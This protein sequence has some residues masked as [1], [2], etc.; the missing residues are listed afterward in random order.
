MSIQ[1]TGVTTHGRGPS[2][3][4]GPP[5]PPTGPGRRFFGSTPPLLPPLTASPLTAKALYDPRIAYLT[6]VVSGWAYSDAATMA[7]QLPYYG[8]PNC[9]IQEFTV[10]ND[11]ML[12]VA[13]AYLVRSEDGSVGVLAF[14]GTMPNDF[15]NWL[16]DADTTLAHFQFGRVHAGFYGNLQ[17][18]WGAIAQAIDDAI[19]PRA[20]ATGQAARGP[21]KNL[22]VTG[23]SLGAAM[24]VVAAAR[25][26][27][28]DYAD[29][30]PYVRGVYT[31]G[32]P[33][34]GDQAFAEHY[35]TQL[36][37]YRHVYRFDVVPH[38]PPSDVGLFPHFGTELYSD[39]TS[40]WEAVVP[41]RT[42]QAGAV[43]A[44]FAVT[45]AS[46][47]ARRF[48]ILRS[49]KLRYSIEDHGPQGY[50]DTSRASL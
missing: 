8:L 47:L 42:A 31:F 44:T 14:R 2:A 23:H 39:G 7:S 50:M 26:F 28:P 34:V 21:L 4:E 25:I 46:F 6:S 36:D 22:Y 49:L 9:S 48:T 35:A 16:T 30:Q 17:P 45:L 3:S 13:A 5:T 27:S 32:Q 20:P 19:E 11:A 12:V 37:L 29:W 10:T 38:L 15:I 40:G 33:S 41:P 1:S 24:A 43:I 18:L